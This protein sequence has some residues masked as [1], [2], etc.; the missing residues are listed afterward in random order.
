VLSQTASGDGPNADLM[1]PNEKDRLFVDAVKRSRDTLLEQIRQ[2]Q[3][4]IDKSKHLLRQM[5]E[6]I[7]KAK[8]P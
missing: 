2:G 1:T 7:D 6:I 5:D 4:A 8:K 3:Q